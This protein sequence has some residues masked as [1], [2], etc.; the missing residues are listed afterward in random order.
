MFNAYPYTDFHELNADWIIAELKRISGELEALYDRAVHDAVEQANAYTDSALHDMREDIDQLEH[1]FS[2]VLSR[3]DSLEY[4]FSELSFQ[5][6]T[7][8][9]NIRAYIDAQIVASNARTD[10]A[11]AANNN[12]IIDQLSQFLSQIKVINFFTGEHVS[13]Q[14]MFN[15][16]CSLHL[17]D[18]IT[19]TDMV[20]RNKTYTQF[21]GLNITY[22]DLV[23]HGNTLYV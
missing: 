23:Q 18:S 2:V 15:Y 3:V 5:I 6:A 17:T 10:A 11:I 22:T 8:I 19:Y 7:E 21:A 13:V 16:L 20:L 12:I 9:S 1:D 4:D 14:D